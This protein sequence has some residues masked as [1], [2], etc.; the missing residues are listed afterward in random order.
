MVTLIKYTTILLQPFPIPLIDP[1]PRYRIKTTI[2]IPTLGY[3]NNCKI[4][5]KA[6]RD[7]PNKTVNL[8]KISV[9]QDLIKRKIKYYINMRQE[10]LLNLSKVEPNKFWR[11]ILTCK[12]K[13]II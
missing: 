10:C 2:G 3:D 1:L 6:I 9:Y 7:A 4:S 5:K 13:K 11:N 8:E 12:R